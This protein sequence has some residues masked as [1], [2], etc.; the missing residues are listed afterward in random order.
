[1]AG[2]KGSVRR[3]RCAFASMTSSWNAEK[4]RTAGTQARPRCSRFRILLSSVWL[5]HWAPA[6]CE[7]RSFELRAR[8]YSAVAI[9][10]ARLFAGASRANF[11]LTL[12]PPTNRW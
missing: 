7:L 12:L 9:S 11:F 2:S 10:S 5:V 3:S 4:V 8:S 1:M 6:S